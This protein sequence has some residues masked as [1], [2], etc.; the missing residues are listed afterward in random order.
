MKIRLMKHLDKSHDYVLN[1]IS[2][3]NNEDGYHD[4]HQKAGIVAS[5]I[6]GAILAPTSVLLLS[7]LQS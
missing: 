4:N 1:H 2:H 3:K 7:Q 6:A 5:E